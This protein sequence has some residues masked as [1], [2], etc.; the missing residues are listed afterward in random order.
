MRDNISPAFFLFLS[1]AG[2][3]F[4]WRF[5]FSISIYLYLLTGC[6]LF[7]AG[8]GMAVYGFACVVPW[9]AW[10][11]GVYKRFLIYALSL[12]MGFILALSVILSLYSEGKN[13]FWGVPYY[14]VKEC[15]G[16]I[17]RD[18]RFIERE[19][20]TRFVVRVDRVSY[21]E[22]EMVGEIDEI[23]LV[24][25]NGKYFFYKGQVI[26]IAAPI[27]PVNIEKGE[28]KWNWIIN[29]SI[30][31][32]TLLGF[33]NYSDFLRFKVINLISKRINRMSY[34]VSE[35]FRALFL[36][37]KGGLNYDFI[38]TFRR[39]GT[40]H[41][42]ALSGLHVG[43][44]F[45]IISFLLLPLGYPLL[46]FGLSSLL[47]FAYLFITGF[48]SSLVRSAL[49]L[50]FFGFCKI[51]DR[52]INPINV[53]SLSAVTILL[54]SPLSLFSLSFQLSF[55]SVLGI[56][57]FGGW[58]IN[59]F[60]KQVPHLVLIPISFGLGAQ[61]AVSPVLIM[62]FG[63]F[64]PVG[65]IASVFIVPL[66]TLYLWTGILLILLPGFIFDVLVGPVS[67][68]LD[69]LHYFILS[70]NKFFSSLP[71][72][73]IESMKNIWGLLWIIVFVVIITLLKVDRRKVTDEL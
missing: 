12:S 10:K 71:G 32:I 34:P 69:F 44:I 38:D 1:L 30:N 48:S 63:I 2:G 8:L 68:L 46:R 40:I 24:F 58:L 29:T 73:K 36:G 61:V 5:Q 9:W 37:F 27:K 42:L 65:V 66:I 15:W 22:G 62:K 26:A 25:V 59:S 43:I 4:F 21:G 54:F 72:V 57:T 7:V 35:L 49:M 70:V 11:S 39:S 41:V 6:A 20:H 14:R 33:D 45:L 47:I 56:V 19:N 17:E 55:L 64:Y 53:L 31:S 16:T 23:A 50:F 52:D 18:S 51:T 3:I 60:G 67:A 28:R 13:R